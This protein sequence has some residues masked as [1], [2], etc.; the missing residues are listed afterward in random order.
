MN[1]YSQKYGSMS[2]HAACQA[3]YPSK[4][5][6]FFAVR[7]TSLDSVNSVQ[8]LKKPRVSREAREA[9]IR[10]AAIRCVLR[11][12]F[13]ASTM[14]AIAR[15]AGL[16]VGIIYRYFANKEAIIE[17]IVIHD[18]EELRLKVAGLDAAGGEKL[19]RSPDN[20]RGFVERQH[21]R[22]RGGLRLEIYAEAAR[23]P[24][25][26]AIVRRTAE[27]ERDLITHLLLRYLPGDTPPAE[28]AGRADVMRIVADG[29]LINGLY[30]NAGTIT[31][32]LPHL[33]DAMTQIFSPRPRA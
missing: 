25:V 21:D 10:E 22:A 7:E 29:L 1:A 23:N 11:A 16:S 28:L 12:G 19:D 2:R 3:I 32:T 20:L 14:D 30:A 5:V 27:I 33:F 6:N 31:D 17:A 24:K 18:L 15:E 9:E 26:A 8:P 13:H 4:G